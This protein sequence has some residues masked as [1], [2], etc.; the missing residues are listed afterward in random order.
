MIEQEVA[1]VWRP[2]DVDLTWG[3]HVAGEGD[4]I[5]PLLVVIDDELRPDSV[6]AGVGQ[7]PVAWIG[8][9]GSSPDSVVHASVSGAL[10]VVLA[11]SVGNVSVSEMPRAISDRFVA[12]TLGRA[13][14][15]EIGHYLLGPRHARRGLMRAR[16]P[17]GDF[18]SNDIQSL[19]LEPDQIIALQT[20]FSAD[21]ASSPSARP[22]IAFACPVSEPK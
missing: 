13:I 1:R 2:Y 17:A 12:L 22:A 9:R 16:V 10:H 19:A 20:R 11:A 5:L 21:G 7:W 4:R 8:F 3:D 18:V 14:A 6:S 15:H